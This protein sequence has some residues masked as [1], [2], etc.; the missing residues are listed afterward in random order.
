[1]LIQPLLFPNFLSKP[2]WRE[3]ALLRNG[4]IINARGERRTVADFDCLLALLHDE[5]L[6]LFV[7]SWQADFPPGWLAVCVE[8]H[9]VHCNKEGE[10]ISIKFRYR[11]GTTRWIY[12]SAPWG[13][14]YP[15]VTFL[16]DLNRIYQSLGV[17]S[18][19]SPGALGST[20]LKHS[21]ARQ[22]AGTWRN[23]RHNRPPQACCDEIK[24][25]AAGA[26]SETLTDPRQRYGSVLEIDIKN[27]YGHAMAQPLPTGKAER[28]FAGEVEDYP[29]YF[30]ESLI[31]IE[32]PLTYGVF[33]IRLTDGSLVYPTQ[34]GVYTTYLA[35]NL[36]ALV[37]EQGL[38]VKLGAGWGWTKTTTDLA[39]FA[40]QLAALRDQA[41]EELAGYYKLLLVAT[42]GSLGMSNERHTLSA[43]GDPDHDRRYV[44]GD[45]ATTWFVL[46]EQVKR[47]GSMPHWMWYILALCQEQLTREALRWAKQELL[48]ATNTDAIYLQASAV[49]SYPTRE[50][51]VSSGTWR[52]RTLYR[53]QFPAVRHIQAYT[54][55]KGGNRVDKRPGVPLDRRATMAYT[56]RKHKDKR[57]GTRRE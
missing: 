12:S 42:V 39:A 4:E 28:F 16:Q 17:G 49:T 46:P 10:L 44:L 37:R 57:D 24:T 29:I 33:P 27:A 1:M 48:L 51:S 20:A 35:S 56:K 22:F 43:S 8:H 34:P 30:A 54:Q 55:K 36:V 52:Q 2:I 5:N 31:T 45:Q 15:T 25:H 13:C 47:P 7:G 21:W 50:E 26:R 3:L 11:G 40:Q 41:E 53:A 19:G 38:S 9:Q 32:A 23:H 14:A 18:A 6:L